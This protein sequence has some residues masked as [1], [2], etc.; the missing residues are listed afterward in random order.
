METTENLS[1]QNILQI[2]HDPFSHY[3]FAWSRMWKYF[4]E[5]LLVTIVSF[6]LLLPTL[7]LNNDNTKI[8]GDKF[9][10]IDLFFISFEG[11]G[12][13]LILAIVYMLL[14]Q[15][16]LEY[17]ISYVNLRAARGEKIH[18]Q[19]MFAAFNNY[20]NAVFA[21]LLV[22]TIIGFGIMLLV[23][24]GIIFA[25]KL[26]FVPYLVVDKKMDAVEAV[27][28]SWEMTGGY[29]MLIFLMGFFT[30]FVV[31]FGLIAFGVGIVVAIIWIRLAFATVYLSTAT[32][33]E[34]RTIS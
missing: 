26:S 22:A 3:G 18:V 33:L 12:A 10:S 17:G 9:V 4:L 7:G 1:E 20:W 23:I 30:I 27:K 6:I 8:F 24:P 29:T 21:N 28:K 34:S 31:I 15:W 16:P 19:N 13:Y 25:C 2:S 32:K 14:F 5:L 11:F